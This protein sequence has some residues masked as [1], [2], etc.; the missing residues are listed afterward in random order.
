MEGIPGLLRNAINSCLPILRRS[1]SI[2]GACSI[3]RVRAILNLD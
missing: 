1:D 2:R 3:L